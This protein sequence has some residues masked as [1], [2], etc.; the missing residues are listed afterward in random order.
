MPTRSS[1][2]IVEFDEATQSEVVKAAYVRQLRAHGYLVQHA[3]GQWMV[4]GCYCCLRAR[5]F[6]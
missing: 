2:T 3:L 6:T 5:A 1:T 4:V